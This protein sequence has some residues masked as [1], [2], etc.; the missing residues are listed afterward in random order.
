MSTPPTRPRALRAVVISC[1]AVALLMAGSLA[2]YASSRHWSEEATLIGDIDNPD[3][4]DIVMWINRV[5]T[6]ASTV[7]VSVIEVDAYGRFA[8][9]QGNLNLPTRLTSSSLVN[10]SVPLPQNDSTPVI[11]QRFGVGGTP[12]DYP[13]DRYTT[14]MAFNVVTDDGTVLP[15]SATVANTD[16]FFWITPTLNTDYGDGLDVDLL[17][18]RSTPTVV[19]A[20]FVMILMLG[21]AAAAVTASYYALRWRRGLVLPA[22][23]MMAA[24]LFALIPLRN[25]VPGGPPIGSLIDFASFFIAE[26]VISISLITSVVLGYRHDIAFERAEAERAGLTIDEYAIGRKP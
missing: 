16:S 24:I 11:E 5:D 14:T 12:T 10:P 13:F 17:M 15:T 18:K 2:L 7:S 23:S 25:A 20:V 6:S 3:R 19:F 1:L 26:A 9:D 22:C 4:V 21:L 8:D